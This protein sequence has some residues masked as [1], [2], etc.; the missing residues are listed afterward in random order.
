MSKVDN[1]VKDTFNYI[2]YNDKSS[3]CGRVYQSSNEEIEDLYSDID[4]TG[5]KVLSV[6]ASG[7][8]PLMAYLKGASK[9]DTFDINKLTLYYYYI[10]IWTMKFFHTFYPEPYLCKEYI[11][12]L[13]S[14]VK[15]NDEN[16]RNSVEYWKKIL[17]RIEEYELLLMFFSKSTIIHLNRNEI[18]E[19][20]YII[21]RNK[22][23][24]FNIDISKENNIDEKYD[25]VITSNIVDWV[26]SDNGNLAEYKKNLSKLVKPKGIILSSN[27]DNERYIPCE[28]TFFDEDFDYRELFAKSANNLDYS[29]GYMYVK[30]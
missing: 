30:R 7:D 13:L 15:P 28:K 23:K 20:N 12:S 11:N 14:Y 4:F 5:K 27:I 1:D 26:Y 29:P 3:G 6:L 25:I 21:S 18:N 10:R 22:P 17:A 19:L 2:L 16:E 24:F 9:V 8:Q